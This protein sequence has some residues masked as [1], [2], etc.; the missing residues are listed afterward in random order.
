MATLTS[1]LIVELLDRASGPAKKISATINRLQAASR[2]NSARMEEMRGRVMGAVGAGYALAKSLSAPIRAGAHFQT[3]LE[4]IRQKAVS[5]ATNSRL[6]AG[7]F[8]KLLLRQINYRA[9]RSTLS[10]DCSVLV[11]AA[12]RMRKMS[13]PH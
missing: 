2:A 9:Q 8:E 4:D 12:R 6:L 3:M 5:P 1:R 7:S 11:S 10:M 13:M